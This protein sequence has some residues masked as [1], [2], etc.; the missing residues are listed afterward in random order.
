[1]ETLDETCLEYALGE[2][3]LGWLL[4]VGNG[5]GWRDCRFGVTAAELQAAL[6]REFP[7][8]MP[9]V[10][11][12]QALATLQDWLQHPGALPAL[13]CAAAGTPFQQR[14]WQALRQIPCG[15]TLSYAAL[16]TRLGMPRAV[17]AVA[18]ACAANPLALLV[19][20]HRVVRSDGGLGGYRWDVARK[21]WL[22]ARESGCDG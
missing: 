13:P 12:Q 21:R 9:G 15:Q 18:G 20:C 11:A 6:A 14:V 2:G 17:R 7:E 22:L 16:A 5:Q 4:I 1:M 10:A 8:A 3:L 19:P